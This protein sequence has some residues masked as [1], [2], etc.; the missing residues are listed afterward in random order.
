MPTAL[1]SVSDKRGL[2]EFARELDE[3]GWLLVASGGTATVIRD[4]GI[5]VTD[6][7]DYTGSRK[8]SASTNPRWNSGAGHPGRSRRIE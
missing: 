7:A 6:V 2:V 1:I 3:L 4:A 5:T 8:N